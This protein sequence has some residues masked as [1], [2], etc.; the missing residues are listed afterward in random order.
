MHWVKHLQA[1]WSCVTCLS[2]VTH[3]SPPPYNWGTRS[4]PTEGISVSQNHIV[5]GVMLL[6]QWPYFSQLHQ[7]MPANPPIG[8]AE[9]RRSSIVRAGVR[10]NSSRCRTNIS[11]FLCAMKKRLF[12][13]LLFFG[14]FTPHRFCW[15]QDLTKMP[16][17]T[18]RFQNALCE[19]LKMLQ[20]VCRGTDWITAVF[21][22]IYN[23]QR[24][25]NSHN[26]VFVQRKP[27]NRFLFCPYFAFCMS[28]RLEQY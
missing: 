2:W 12:V 9:A 14:L 7:T 23:L 20:H 17:F 13:L 26:Q 11:H 22:E 28:T 25:A 5:P 19:R 24:V 3:P 27:D 16:A 21:Q 15:R 10:A 1:G 4:R 18:G 8:P 6:S